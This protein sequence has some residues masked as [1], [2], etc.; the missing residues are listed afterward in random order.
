MSALQSMTFSFIL[1]D[2]QIAERTVRAK[3]EKEARDK[4]RGAVKRGKRF[5]KAT[6]FKRIH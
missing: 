1:D 2:W 6:S 3:T 5:K 4:I